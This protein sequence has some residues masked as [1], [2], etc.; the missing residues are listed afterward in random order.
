MS[1]LT[2]TP[3]RDWGL[4]AAWLRA[5]WRGTDAETCPYHAGWREAYSIVARIVRDSPPE[6][7]E[8]RLYA[9]LTETLSTGGEGGA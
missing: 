5:E 3:F 4:L 7:R 9:F 1:D 6:E 2:V 8:A